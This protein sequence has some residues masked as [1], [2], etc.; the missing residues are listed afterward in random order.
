[1]KINISKISLF[2]WLGS[3]VFFLLT[4]T[5]AIIIKD[6]KYPIIPLITIGVG[7]FAFVLMII[8]TVF[9]NYKANKKKVNLFKFIFY[10]LLFPFIPLL[11]LISY[12]LTKK[13]K[14]KKPKL[15]NVSPLLLL[16][17]PIWILGYLTLGFIIKQALGYN[18]ESITISGTGSM[19]PTFPKGE[20][21]DPKELSKQIMGTQGMF[22]YP[23]GLSIFGKRLFEHQIA[24]GDIIIVEDEKTREKTEKTYGHPGGWIKRVIGLPGDNIE[25]KGGIVYVNDE[26]LREPYTAQPQ[27]TFGETFLNE[28]KKVKVPE[29]NIF[30]LGDNRKGSGDSREVGF[31]DFSAINHVLP[32]TKQ[33]GTLDTHWRETSK[34]FDESSKIKIEKQKYLELLNEKRKEVKVQPLKYQPKLEKSAFKRGEVILKYD[35]FSFEATKSGYTMIRAMNDAGYSNTT[36]GEAPQQGYYEADELIENQFEF[37]ETKGFLLN[38]NYQEIG[39]AEVEGMLNGCPTQILVQHFAGYIPPNY[40]QT[41]IDGWEQILNRLKEIRPNWE[42]VKNSPNLYPNNKDKTERLLYILNLR[43]SRIEAIVA[44]MKANQWLTNEENK[45]TNEDQGLYNEQVD[46][47]NYLNSQKW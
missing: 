14:K 31:F 29:N 44:R 34:D 38:K 26:P 21:R 5:Y 25:I 11:N 24:R 3:I 1:M 18:Q 42:N 13:S 6:F 33:K 17:G 23:N 9:N 32:L 15:F 39:I 20:G 37:P 28:C 43:I 2:T 7:C 35:D 12:L 46:I 40:K 4:L 27:S 19:Y 36:Y 30:I 10:L 47:S 45:Y 41:D 8:S 16:V 22:R